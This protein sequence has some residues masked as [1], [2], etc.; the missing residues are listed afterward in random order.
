MIRA[1]FLIALPF[2]MGA[3]CASASDFNPLGFYLGGAVGHAD[4]RSTVRTEPTYELD[5]SDTGWKVLVGARP[6]RMFAAELEYVDFG[7]SRSTSYVGSFIS[8]SNTLQRAAGLSGLVYLPIPL[9]LLEIYARAGVA[10]LESSGGNQVVCNPRLPCPFLVV[11]PSSFN[12][13]D[14]D[15]LYGAGLQAKLPAVAVRLE[16][17]RINDHSGDPDMVSLGLTWTF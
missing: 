13:T 9:P 15:L 14:T 10:R 6:L 12:R 8:E 17:E 11:A 5:K 7:H 4:V 1:A 16:Y 2:A 3:T